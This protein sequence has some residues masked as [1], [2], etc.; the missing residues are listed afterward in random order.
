MASG[1]QTY[2]GICADLPQAPRNR[3]SAA[4]VQTPVPSAPALARIAWMSSVPAA[5]NRSSI[6]RRNPTSPMRLVM[7]AFRPASAHDIFVV[8]S[9]IRSYQNPISRYEQRPT[10]SQPTNTTGS[11]APRTSVSIIPMNRFR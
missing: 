3:R 8:S 11:D 4:A 2:S 9:N 10:P 7:N 6:P 5:V 1:S